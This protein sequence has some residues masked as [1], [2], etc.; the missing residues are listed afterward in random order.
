MAPASIPDPQALAALV[1]QRH[2]L[3][4]I[5]DKISNDAGLEARFLRHKR[6]LLLPL[7]KGNQKTQWPDGVQRTLGRL[8]H[9]GKPSSAR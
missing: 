4:L 1:E 3:T 2:D 8:R 9:R 6:I 7:R 5:G